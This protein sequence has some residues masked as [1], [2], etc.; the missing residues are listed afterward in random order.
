VKKSNAF[1]GANDFIALVNY[2]AVSTC[3]GVIKAGLQWQGTTYIHPS[4]HPPSAWCGKRVD[5]EH[6]QHP[7]VNADVV[8]ANSPAVSK[9]QLMSG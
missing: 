8:V 6:Q 9:S 7:R 3:T 5:E 1:V 4:L 2:K